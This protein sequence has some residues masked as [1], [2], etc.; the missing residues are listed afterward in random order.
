L[1]HWLVVSLQTPLTQVSGEQQSELAP[2]SW[3]VEPQL[4]LQT[5]FTQSGSEAQQPPSE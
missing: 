2:Q 3:P 1:V 4:T 5:S